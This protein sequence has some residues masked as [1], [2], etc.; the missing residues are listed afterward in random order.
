[1]IVLQTGRFQLD[2]EDV[3][4]AIKFISSQFADRKTVG[5]D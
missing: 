2:Y 5:D 1:M 4:G 3:T